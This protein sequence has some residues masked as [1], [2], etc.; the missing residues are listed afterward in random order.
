MQFRNIREELEA[1][2]SRK[3]IERKI[4]KY[5]E[6]KDYF[7]MEPEI[8]QDYDE[9]I[10]SN[11]RQDTSKTVKVLGGDSK[12]Y[13]LRPDITT[14]ILNQVS[15][16]WQG[17]SPLR[18]YYNSK[19]YRNEK[20]GKISE[21]YQMGAESIGDEILKGDR[22]ILEMVMSLMSSLEQDYILEVSSSK[23]LDGLFTEL[24]LKIE[25]EIEIKNLISKKNKHGLEKKLKDLKLENP[26]LENIFKMQGNISR[27]V[28][29]AK[30]YKMNEEM[31]IAI[32]SL[33]R[34]K[35]FFKEADDLT[36]IQV[37]LSLVADFDY[38][39]GIIFKGYCRNLPSR[40]LSGGRYDKATKK[41]GL[42]VPA[43]GFM[44]DMDLVSEI[45]FKE[46]YN[47]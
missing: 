12:I 37:D 19:V 47:G 36:K 2:K 31:K 35:D 39:D 40:I 44:I 26:L 38:Y 15:S 28:E 17:K 22:E 45:K 27:V 25:D 1:V 16:K 32:D 9:F 11:F 24:N 3:N 23:Y 42:E 13:I 29:I 4:E 7:I 6:S 34:I 33:E 30:K 18:V 10:Y 46:A 21:N 5:F 41:M 8:F 14:N 43:I 20:K